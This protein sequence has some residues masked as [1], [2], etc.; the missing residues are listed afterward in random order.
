MK[1]IDLNEEQIEV[2]EN[3][4]STFDENFITYKMNGSIQIGIEEDGKIL[5]K[6]MKNVQTNIKNLDVL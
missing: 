5:I 4:L 2:V 3:K 1:I 6:E